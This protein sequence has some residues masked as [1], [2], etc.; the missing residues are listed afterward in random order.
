MDIYD[1]AEQLKK[2]P[3][4]S[5][6]D[7]AKLNL[8]AFTSEMMT[9]REGD[10]LFRLGEPSDSVYVVLKGTVDV[11][12]DENPDKTTLI[13]NLGQNHMLGEMGVFLNSPRSASMLATSQ[14]QT[15]KIPAHRF[16]KLATETPAIALSVMKELSAKIAFTGDLVVQSSAELKKLK[17]QY[18]AQ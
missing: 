14:V 11:I 4:F 2:V 17:D 9:F 6:C 8:L 3:L 10:Y 5:S 16:I 7:K 18:C 13:A 15:L 12:Y 1:N